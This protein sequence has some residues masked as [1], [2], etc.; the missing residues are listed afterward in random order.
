MS[1]AVL[2][3]KK[4]IY[5]YYFRAEQKLINS[6]V[7]IAPPECFHSTT[8][9]TSGAVIP[10]RSTHQHWSD[11]KAAQPAHTGSKDDEDNED[12]EKD[13]DKTNSGQINGI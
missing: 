5:Y 10:P 8:V 6:G 13:E 12:D 7:G 2:S 1:P 4:Q 9:A 11:F 3:K